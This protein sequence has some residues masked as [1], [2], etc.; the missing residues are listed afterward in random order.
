MSFY[1]EKYKKIPADIIRRKIYGATDSD[2][3]RA[4][5]L[6]PSR[7]SYDDFLALLS[8]R[9]EG[10]IGAMSRKS[11]AL[12]LKY[13]GKN[14]N[15]YAPLYLSNFCSNTCRYC[16]FNAATGG[17]F[18]RRKLTPDEIAA[19]GDWL[20]K[21]GFQS[22]LLLT[23]E[24]PE[25]AGA[26]YVLEAVNI[27]K[28]K[29]SFIGLEIF[30]TD[31]KNYKR[32]ALAGVSGLTIYQETYNRETY[33]D[34]HPSG[35]KRDF[36]YRLETPERALASGIRRVG[37]G[38]LLG[39]HGDWRE[40][41]AYLGLHA[42]YLAKKFWRSEITISFPRLRECASDFTPRYNVSDKE[43]AWMIFAMRIWQPHS[44]ILLSTRERQEFRDSLIGWGVTMMSAASKTSPGGYSVYKDDEKES[45]QFYVSDKRGVAE[46]V[47]AITSRGCWAVFKDWDPNFSAIDT[48]L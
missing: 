26:D 35:P 36:L 24:S 22:V 40:D 29:F 28:K 10:F 21:Q 3:K 7:I 18:V 34:V 25:Q 48:T 4:L 32:F 31:E 19:E 44:A 41:I 2:V 46:V 14:I 5:L 9:A 17:A 45:G 12:T 30:P 23:G 43:I 27:L 37:I 8:P 39:L 6:A 38:A 16:G 15:L 42:E 13:F 33:L 11:R 47:R 20:K 1:E